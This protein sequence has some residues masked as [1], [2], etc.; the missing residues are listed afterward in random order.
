MGAYA[1]AEPL[2]ER[3]LAIS[4]KQLGP[5]HPSTA[6][7]LNNLAGLYLSIGAYAKVEPLYLRALS[8]AMNAGQPELLWH[9]QN[10]LH[11]LLAKQN[12]P[13]LAIFFGKQAV[14]T[15]QS[16]RAGLTKMD[17]GM[18]KS[19]LT[20]KE[21][22]YKRLSDLLIDQGRL[23]E[24]QQVI[25]M[26]K[27]EEYFDY[28]RRDTGER[29][30]RSTQAAFTAAEAPW[31]KRYTEIS[32]QIM[33]LGREREA[34]AKAKKENAG[35]TPEQE[36]RWQQ[37]KKDETVAKQAFNAAIEEMRTAFQKMGTQRVED[38]GSM[39]LKSLQALQTTLGKMGHGAV[40]I[41]TLITDDKLRLLLTTPITQ[42][43]RD[44]PVT[45]AVLNQK[46]AAYREVLQNPRRNPLP[47]ARE[48]YDLVIAP[49]AGDL[50]Q[51]EAKTLMISLDDTLRYLPL[52]ALHDGKG[53]LTEHYAV[54]MFTE[55]AKVHLQTIPTPEWRMAGLGVSLEL[56]GF[57]PLPAVREELS[58]LVRQEGDKEAKGVLPGV[59][60]LDQA[61]TPANL[62]DVLTDTYPVIH[63]ASHFVFSPGTEDRSFL[64]LGDGKQLSL[65]DIKN[66]PYNFGNVDLLTLSAC[67][68]AVG[69]KDAKGR[70]VEGFG[71]LAQN[72]GAKGV[73]ATLW[74]VADRST[75][76]FMQ[77]F[78]RLRQEQHLTKA[79]ALRQAQLAFINPAPGSTK[80]E[81]PGD[82]TRGRLEREGNSQS[83]YYPDPQAPYAHP[84][85]W[86]PFILMGNWL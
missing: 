4:E 46:I 72:Q 41:N 22:V 56:P 86:A 77:N 16:L 58:G 65:A 81:N 27:E 59:V 63:L 9:V 33:C 18:Q 55:A 38:Y 51:A 82:E 64:L 24:A 31:V 32:G 57:Q 42:L 61:F 73:M 30:P 48:L 60:Y 17:K 8:I 26:L 69:G 84:Y 6:T 54:V 45:A 1:K 39:H 5:E 7:S 23:P 50:E 68:T 67:E 3:A 14:N 49:L 37:L 66:G 74:P 21:D 19:F 71:A 35:L 78:Y 25:A 11:T 76:I 53:Y 12:K 47:L 75:G 70:E 85:F 15:I 44:S 13:D 29:D 36:T 79:E 43:H 10:D 28:V 80:P 40:V 52:A 83:P 34:L 20:D 2:Y 62:E